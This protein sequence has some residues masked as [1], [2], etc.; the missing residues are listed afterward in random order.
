MSES[1]DYEYRYQDAKRR[2]EN[3]DPLNTG[4]GLNYRDYC[5]LKALSEQKQKERIEQNVKAY[6]EAVSSVSSTTNSNS[7]EAGEFGIGGIAIVI[8]II[9]AVFAWTKNGGH[10]V[11]QTAPYSESIFDNIS[12]PKAAAGYV[13]IARDIPLYT[14]QRGEAIGQFKYGISEDSILWFLKLSNIEHA[15]V[16]YNHASKK[17][18]FL[19]NLPQHWLKMNDN[20]KPVKAAWFLTYTFHNFNSVD[21]NTY[22]KIRLKNFQ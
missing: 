1:T 17:M 19:K 13:N 10:S 3:G 7:G 12:D 9:A 18:V 21:S 20:K 5:E 8:V 11:N 6:N 15:E 4:Y 2:A 16:K 22:K 14:K